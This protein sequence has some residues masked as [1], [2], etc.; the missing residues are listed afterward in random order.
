MERTLSEAGEELGRPGIVG[1]QGLTCTSSFQSLYSSFQ[2]SKVIPGSERQPQ[3]KM[4]S[5]PHA[6]YCWGGKEDPGRSH[7]S[8]LAASPCAFTFQRPFFVSFWSNFRENGIKMVLK[9]VAD[10]MEK[11][12]LQNILGNTV[13]FRNIGAQGL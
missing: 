3:S 8:I 6:R 5:P 12:N 9:P 4:L 1:I 7:L 13:G 2:D 10:G 11:S